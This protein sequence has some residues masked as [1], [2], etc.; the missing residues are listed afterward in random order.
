MMETS[1]AENRRTELFAGAPHPIPIPPE[2]NLERCRAFAVTMGPMRDTTIRRGT[3]ADLEAMV[4]TLARAFAD[5]PV[6]G[7]WAFPDRARA[8]EQRR[9]FFGLWVE[10][11]LRDGW[12]L[13]T[14]GCEA[15]ASWFPPGAGDDT[16][17]D[18][19]RFRALAHEHLGAR[20]PLFLEGC[21]LIERS[22]R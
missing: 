16:P 13:V 7:S 22:R 1:S 3:A 20:A 5:D 6:W 4:T 19:A 17:Q 14:G 9:V 2:V 18:A 21:A 11:S 15:V 12:V 8:M 10:M